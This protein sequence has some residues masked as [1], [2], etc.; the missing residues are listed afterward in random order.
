MPEEVV[1]KKKRGRPRKN[2]PAPVTSSPPYPSPSVDPDP[3]D[4]ATFN[5]ATDLLKITL[6][7]RQ[8]KNIPTAVTDCYRMAKQLTTL[9]REGEPQVETVV[10][11]TG[12]NLSPENLA[13]LNW[14]GDEDIA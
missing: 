13:A 10:E 3:F 8:G 4:W 1:A 7:A 12:K 6:Q 11:S 9:M 2:T 14:D 5:V